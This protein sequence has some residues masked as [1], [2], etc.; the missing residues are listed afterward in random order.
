MLLRYVLLSIALALTVSAGDPQT[1]LRKPARPA[2]PPVVTPQP[3]VQEL[4]PAMVVAAPNPSGGTP[5]GAAGAVDIFD[6]GVNSNR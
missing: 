5:A 2:Q 3:P 1:A 6:F 4:V